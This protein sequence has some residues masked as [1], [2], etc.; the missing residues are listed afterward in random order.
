MALKKSQLYQQNVQELLI[1]SKLQLIQR[2]INADQTLYKD[3]SSNRAHVA[4][5]SDS[6]SSNRENI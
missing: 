6:T 1:S 2:D 5:G 4:V 3:A